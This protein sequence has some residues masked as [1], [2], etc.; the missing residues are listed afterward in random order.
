MAYEHTPIAPQVAA[1]AGVALPPSPET[2]PGQYRTEQAWMDMAK[3]STLVV[4][5]MA[6]RALLAYWSSM[7]WNAAACDV[8]RDNLARIDATIA[9]RF[10]KVTA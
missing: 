3:H 5:Q 4:E 8:L 9:R 6:D 1:A 7:G 10:P 2:N